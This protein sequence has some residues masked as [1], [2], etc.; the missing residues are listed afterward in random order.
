MF[1][2]R[3]IDRD[4]EVTIEA[5]YDRIPQTGIS[6]SR[7]LFIFGLWFLGIIWPDFE[8]LDNGQ[9]VEGKESDWE[10]LRN[11]IGPLIIEIS[12]C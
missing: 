7:T 3:S 6:Q 10:S 11:S 1:G 4:N 9:R 12:F 5:R 8:T 2:L